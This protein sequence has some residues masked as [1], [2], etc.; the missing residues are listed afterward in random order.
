MI[1][2]FTRTTASDFELL[3]M[4]HL[5]GLYRLAYRLT[6]KREDAEDLVQ[7]VLVKVFPRRHELNVEG[8]VRAWLA[9]IL[10]RMFVDQWRSRQSTPVSLARDADP[11]AE[12]DPLDNYVAEQE[13][14]DHSAF[15]SQRQR[16]LLTA[17]GQLSE[18]HRSILILHDVEG[19]CLSELEHILELPLGTLK[20]RLHRARANLRA[21][22]SPVDQVESSG[23]R[24]L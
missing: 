9:K 10:Y 22:L 6:G 4:P 23:Q 3:V 8:H 16:F 11:S 24:W 18:D 21:A 2:G 14:V 7:D 12:G 13:S 19:Y 15:C 5:A 20:S 17:L 1:L